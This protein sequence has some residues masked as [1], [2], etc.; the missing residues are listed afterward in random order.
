M[1]SDKI[2]TLLIGFK[3]EM[4]DY[5]EEN[6]VDIQLSITNKTSDL[7]ALKY[8]KSI[9]KQE[10]PALI[11]VN[12]RLPNLHCEQLIKDLKSKLKKAKF[13]VISEEKNV[14]GLEKALAAGADDFIEKPLNL[15]ELRAR[16]KAR[17]QMDQ[18]DPDTIEYKDLTI[19][20][21]SKSLFKGNKKIKLTH[22]EWELLEFFVKNQGKVFSRSKLLDRVWGRDELVVE[23]SVD[24]YVS[25]LREKLVKKGEQNEYIQTKAGFGYMMQK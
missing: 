17:L 16:I 18:S 8:L 6:L 23:R 14:A 10:K 24:V 19:N 2:D 1:D 21:K 11:L 22:K 3:K 5:I 20:L 13:I 15:R 9:S 25:R 7:V 4:S 12:Y